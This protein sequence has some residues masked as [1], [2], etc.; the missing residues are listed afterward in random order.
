MGE[1]NAFRYP[2]DPIAYGVI[3]GGLPLATLRAID[4]VGARLRDGFTAYDRCC[5]CLNVAPRWERQL[6]AAGVSARYVGG[7]PGSPGPRYEHPLPPELLCGYRTSHGLALHFWLL[8]GDALAL[9]DPTAHQFDAKG[10]V[11]LDRYILDGLSLPVWRS[12]QLRHQ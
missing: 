2:D 11:A 1:L 8:L 4:R 9:F 10:G 6:R 5:Q 3:E 12:R 7:D